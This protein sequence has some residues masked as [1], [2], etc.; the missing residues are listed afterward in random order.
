MRYSGSLAIQLGG[1]LITDLA[2]RLLTTFQKGDPS[3]GFILPKLHS[4][5]GLDGVSVHGRQI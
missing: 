3:S 1:L 2:G 5:C 4:K